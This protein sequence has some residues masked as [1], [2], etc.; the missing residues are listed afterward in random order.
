MDSD[1]FEKMAA[2]ELRNYIRFLLWHYRVVDA[3]WYIN[4]S[5]RFNEETADQL[6][7]KVWGR[8]TSMAAKDLVRRFNIREKALKGL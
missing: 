4:V 5:E 1:I 8:V 7:E 2:P 6:N 3:F